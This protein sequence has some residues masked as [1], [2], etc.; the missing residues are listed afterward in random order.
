MSWHEPT[1]EMMKAWLDAQQ[2]WW[3]SWHGVLQASTAPYQQMVKQWQ[4][5]VQQSLERWTSD[6]SSAKQVA[7]QWVTGQAGMLRFVE[8]VMHAWEQVE[9]QIKMGQDWQA[10]LGD[11]VDQMREQLF[12][13]AAGVA[14]ATDDMSELWSVYLEEMQRL[15]QL[16]LEPFNHAPWGAGAAPAGQSSEVVEMT[17]LFWEAFERTF[18]TLL[19]SPSLGYTRELNEKIAQGFESWLD[20]RRA[21]AAYQARL[22]DAWAEAFE[23]LLG[24]MVASAEEGSTIG[25]MRDLLRLWGRVADRVFIE[26]F[27]TDEYIQLQGHLLN[28]SMKYRIQQREIVEV[29][30]SAA[31][32]PTR[33]EVDEAHRNIYALR[34]EI[35]QLERTVR[36]L[37]KPTT[38]KR[39]PS[40]KSTAPA[41]QST[42]TTERDEEG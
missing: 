14:Q 15:G 34:K 38:R 3:Q 17:N 42:S 28:A 40:R 5:L 33:H 30:Q 11:Y 10:S 2:N 6:E 32:L 25:T 13:S 36:D 23:V 21:S 16:W 41:A 8:M 35:R 24:E 4:D 20:F 22:A 1:E 9:A 26:T 27:H 31:D 18:G 7:G 37:Q 19:Q 39:S 12:P 29:F